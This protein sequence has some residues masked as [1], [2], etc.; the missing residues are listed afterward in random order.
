METTTPSE[1]PPLLSPSEALQ[2]FDGID[3][4]GGAGTTTTTDLNERAGYGFRVGDIGLLIGPD[5]VGEVLE[6]RAIYPVP[7]TPRW[8]LGLINLRGNLVPVFDLRRLLNP[9]STP[10]KVGRLLILDEDRRTLAIPI[11][12]LPRTVSRTTRLTHTP[13]LPAP[14]R[15]HVTGAYDS[16]GSIW[17]QFDHRGMFLSLTAE[18]TH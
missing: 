16:D 7:H 2:Q 1:W 3:R 13:P 5:T 17:L 6:P 8:L 11:D 12:D 15:G 10:T 14:L 4:S 9:D 18:Y